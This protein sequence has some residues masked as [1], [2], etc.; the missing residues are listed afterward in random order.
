MRILR[1]IC[2]CCGQTAPARKQWWNQDKGYGVCHRCFDCVVQ[3]E[4]M[5]RARESYGL[6]GVN[7]S[8]KKVKSVNAD[9]LRC[10][11]T[12]RIAEGD[13]QIVFKGDN[14]GFAVL[15][16]WLEAH[17]APYFV[18]RKSKQK[19]ICYVES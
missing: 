11:D 1:L 14:G 16:L 5:D 3:K 10:G 12:I 8:L 17:N 9:S 13:R 7:H 2:A 4:G 19:L 15:S 18:G 6:E